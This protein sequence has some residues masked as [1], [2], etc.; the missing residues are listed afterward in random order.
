[1]KKKSKESLR[2][3]SREPGDPSKSPA[4]ILRNNKYLIGILILGIAL[5]GAAVILGSSPAA[6]PA[7]PF[8]KAPGTVTVWYFYGNGCEHCENV[9]PFVRSLQAR[10]PAVEFQILEIYDNTAN[11]DRLLSLNRQY[12]QTNTG[13][14]VA[15]V[16]NVVLF[17]ANE[18]PLNLEKEIIRQAYS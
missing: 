4:G 9:T 1:L 12:H 17:G 18:I 5:A 6:P 15:F 11:R 14:P 3:P 13:I 16:G 10:Y 2:A 7:R 8:P